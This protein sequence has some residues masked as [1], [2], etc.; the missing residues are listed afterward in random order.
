M[1]DLQRI[2]DDYAKEMQSRI[3][4]DKCKVS[5]EHHFMFMPHIDD[6]VCVMCGKSMYSICYPR[7]EE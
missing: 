1:D 2:S 5:N 3:D 6:Y 7:K 4:K